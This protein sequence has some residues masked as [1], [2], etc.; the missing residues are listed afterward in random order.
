MKV[1]P[2]EAYQS[3]YAGKAVKFSTIRQ[4]LCRQMSA[5]RVSSGPEQQCSILKEVVYEQVTKP[6]SS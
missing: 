6:G 5:D 2:L 4:M 1:G 3:D